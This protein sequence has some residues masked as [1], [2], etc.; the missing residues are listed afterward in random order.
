MIAEKSKVGH[1]SLVVLEDGVPVPYYIEEKDWK[2]AV[3]EIG[4]SALLYLPPSTGESDHGE[5]ILDGIAE[6]LQIWKTSRRVDF[7]GIVDVHDGSSS[8]DGNE[9]Q[10]RLQQLEKLSPLEDAPTFVIGKTPWKFCFWR[11]A[12]S[13][14]LEPQSMPR[15]HQ[16]STVVRTPSMRRYSQNRHPRKNNAKEGTNRYQTTPALNAEALPFLPARKRNVW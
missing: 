13:Q 7:A 4:K 14:I 15:T 12:N 5:C 2:N 16:T 11:P 10:S 3:P 6:Q 8:L 9:N 1:G